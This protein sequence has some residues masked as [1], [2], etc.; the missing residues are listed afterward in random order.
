[1]DAIAAFSRK[2]F[3]WL[4]FLASAVFAAVLML[5]SPMFT[6]DYDFASRHFSS[7]SEILHYCLHYGNG[8]LIGNVGA[9]LFA[10]SV[11]VRTVVRALLLAGLVV[12]LPMTVQ[13]RRKTS[14]LLSF[15]LVFG[16]APT[17]FAEVYSWA[18]GFQNYVPPVFLLTLCMLLWQS[19][20]RGRC[21]LWLRCAA[22]FLLALAGQL[23]V[24]LDTIVCCLAALAALIL[25]RRHSAARKAVSSL[26]LAGTLAGGAVMLV[27]P[28]LFEREYQLIAFYRHVYLSSFREML[29]SVW[30]NGLK[31]IGFFSGACF[32]CAAMGLAVFLLLGKT[33][34]AWRRPGAWRACRAVSLAL[35][36]YSLIFRAFFSGGR[37][38]W[39]PALPK[40][41]FALLCIGFLFVF[42]C[43]AAHAGD[44]TLLVRVCVLLGLAV[45]SIG[46]MLVV[47][48]APERSVY[49]CYV[50]LSCAAL[51][52]FEFLLP[53]MSAA[54]QKPA[55]LGACLAAG[56]L[57]LL[58][59]LQFAA[60]AYTDRL[61][62]E[63]IERQLA[64]GSTQIALITPP[65]DYVY[66]NTSSY[67][68][69]YYYLQEPNDV[70]FTFTDYAS[71][72]AARSL[73]QQAGS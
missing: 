43:A 1:M 16:V 20:D 38:V 47:Y 63:Y 30:T 51:A 22:V 11:P 46:P 18:S 42:I 15:L 36:L 45:C 68:G 2:K 3:L 32:L 60:V 5:C 71:W 6:D 72:S 44:R 41:L 48:P 24:E 26:W 73:E 23:Y 17:M 14:W 10:A 8:R 40:L 53:S 69:H 25:S 37:F 29:D 59:L 58:L 66:R 21:P 19:A 4:L 34:G 50:L 67:V 56:I 35:P 61:N 65:S 55:R 64:A 12:L 70:Q 13:A 28:R 54:G 49:L 9:A 52:V 7:F 57:S 39:L 31:L 27:I 62:T 33:R